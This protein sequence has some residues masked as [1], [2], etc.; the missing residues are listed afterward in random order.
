MFKLFGVALAWYGRQ[1]YDHEMRELDRGIREKALAEDVVY[2][3][4]G[5]NAPPTMSSAPHD[6]EGLQSFR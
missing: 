4:L 6:A 3:R 5:D 2:R 1:R